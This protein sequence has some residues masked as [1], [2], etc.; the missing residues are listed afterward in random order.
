MFVFSL[1]GRTV[2]G[3]YLVSRDVTSKNITVVFLFL[4]LLSDFESPHSS[5]K[6]DLHK[7]MTWQKKQKH[8]VWNCRFEG[9]VFC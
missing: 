3:C 9:R 7:A 4:N 8:Q 1:Q 2:N 6:H 5:M